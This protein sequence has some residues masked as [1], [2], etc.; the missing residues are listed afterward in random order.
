MGTSLV[1]P[2][3]L[4]SAASVA[5]LFALTA[6][7]SGTGGG[8]GGGAGGGSGGGSD[9]SAAVSG[10]TDTHCTDV[11]GGAIVQSVSASSCHPD[12]GS[13]SDGGTGLD[14]GDTLFNAEGDDD[15]CKYHV[16][17]TATPVA[18]NENVAFTVTVTTKA[19]HQPV[20]SAG[21]LAEVFLSDVH[22]APNSGQATTGG[23]NG[24]YTVGPIRF[25]ASGRWTAKTPSTTHRTATPPSTSMFPEAGGD[26]SVRSGA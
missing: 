2:L 10:A 14:Y 12:A 3:L 21:T 19:D 23:T 18:K 9:T 17:W 13:V 11:D 8:S 22:P 26:G 15:D 16:K 24:V 25:D 4:F 5:V 6:G 7:C 1:R 20:L